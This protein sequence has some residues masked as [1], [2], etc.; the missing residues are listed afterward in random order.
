MEQT[1][2]GILD[3]RQSGSR[4]GGPSF[5]LRHR[6][7]RAAWT[8]AWALLAAWTPAPMHRWR[9]ML[10]RLFGAQLASNARVH[11]SAR[12][13]YP[14][15]LAMEENALIGPRVICYAMAPVRICRNAVVSQGAHLCTG[16]H[17]VDDPHF[18]LEAH[19]ITI[20]ANAWVAAEAFVGPGVILQ[21]G[22]I[23]GARGVAFGDIP[24][25]TI[26][27]GNPA[28]PLRERVR[29]TSP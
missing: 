20:G 5:S 3:A 10:L 15:N 2:L 17:A 6:M 27:A 26:Y 22:A 1:A 21:E 25:W 23:L 29:F 9:A 12:I 7:L 11:G 4:T 8:V 28:R 14:P 16:S 19:P 13:W 18:Q 24:A